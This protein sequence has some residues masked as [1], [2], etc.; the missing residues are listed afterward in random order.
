MEIGLC[1]QYGRAI[2]FGDI[3]D[4]SY[5]DDID[6]FNN[7]Q[8]KKLPTRRFTSREQLIADNDLNIRE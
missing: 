1:L 3:T 7:E 5:P 6:N 4:V 2:L 8:M